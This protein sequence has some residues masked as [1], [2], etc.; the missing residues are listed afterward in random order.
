MSQETILR[1]FDLVNRVGGQK[2]QASLVGFLM[3]CAGGWAWAVAPG[4]GAGVWA[5]PRADCA[6]ARAA[7]GAA[8]GQ[9]GEGCAVAGGLGGM[10]GAVEAA[11][12]P[13]AGD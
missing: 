8:V 7:S 5:C 12:Q 13:A 3:L 6:G 11:E 9:G 4:G 1:Y 10:G 2:I